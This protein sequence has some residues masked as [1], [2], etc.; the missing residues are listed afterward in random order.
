MTRPASPTVLVSILFLAV[1]RVLG[2]SAFPG[3]PCYNTCQGGQPTSSGDIV[4]LDED[5]S[6]SAKGQRLQSCL[7]CL[8]SSSHQSGPVSDATLFSYYIATVQQTCLSGEPGAPI[9]NCG[10]KCAD[11]PSAFTSVSGQ[12]FFASPWAYCTASN[13]TYQNE[14][15]GCALCLQSQPHTVVLGNCKVIKVDV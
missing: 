2:L 11:L 7:S 13:N 12:A 8:Q 3:S 6:N 5:W 1:G 9:S 4:C 10:S 14:G 15:P